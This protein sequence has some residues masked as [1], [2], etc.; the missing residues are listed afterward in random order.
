M[1]QKAGRRLLKQAS[2]CLKHRL[3]L[4]FKKNKY[5][6]KNTALHRLVI[7]CKKCAPKT[8]YLKVVGMTIA[9]S[10]TCL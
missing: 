8:P 6:A 7:V 3:I 10:S 5:K 1:A 4:I 2:G 9:M